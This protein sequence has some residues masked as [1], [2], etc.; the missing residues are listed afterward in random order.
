MLRLVRR[1]A[2]A[3]TA[4]TYARMSAPISLEYTRDRAEDLKENIAAVQ[5]D[6]AHAAGAGAK[7]CTEMRDA[8]QI[9]AACAD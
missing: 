4:R 7:V 3:T 8:Q 1:T 6:V 5:H 2:A 9:A